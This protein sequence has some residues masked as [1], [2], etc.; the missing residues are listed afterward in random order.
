MSPEVDFNNP[1]LLF[2][3]VLERVELNVLED[4][5]YFFLKKRIQIQLEMIIRD[6]HT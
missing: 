1:E 2:R 4:V 6:R 5:M 3:V